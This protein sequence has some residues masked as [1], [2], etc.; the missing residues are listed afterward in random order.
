M[1]QRR[2]DSSK[3]QPTGFEILQSS[4]AIEDLFRYRVEGG[5]KGRTTGSRATDDLFTLAEQVCYDITGYP[6]SGKTQFLFEYLKVDA[7]KNGSKIFAYCPDLGSPIEALA[8]MVHRITGKTFDKEKGQRYGNYIKESELIGEIDWV[9]EH[10]KFVTKTDIKAK[11]TPYDFWQWGVE[12]GCNIL[13]VDAWKDL[14]HDESKYKRSDQYLEDVLG[15]RNQ[16]AEDKRVQIHTV[17]HPKLPEPRKDGKRTVPGPYHLKGGSEWFNAGRV[18]L[19]V[20]RDPENYGQTQIYCTKNKP[21]SV[22]NVDNTI[23]SFDAHKFAY[24]DL[25]ESG[26]RIYFGEE[27][28]AQKPEKPPQKSNYDLNEDDYKLIDGK[29]GQPF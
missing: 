26:N 12:S 11:L 25:D 2:R 23:I 22:A 14:Y 16:I 19:T 4:S 13:V 3:S 28:V 7:Q 24:Y 1:E 10:F 21:R 18:M 8:D 15:A 9:L 17:I 20:D 29:D 5:I 27:K 6:R